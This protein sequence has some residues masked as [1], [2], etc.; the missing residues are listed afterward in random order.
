MLKDRWE[1]QDAMV[2]GPREVAYRVAPADW[3]G[4][5][6]YLFCAREYRR[7]LRAERGLLT[8]DEKRTV[9]PAA[10]DYA[11]RY[12]LKIFMGHKSPR[13]DGHGDYHSCCTFD[14][15]RTILEDCRRRGLTRLTA[16]LVGWGLDGHD[17]RYPSRFPVDDRLGGEAGLKRLLAWCREVDILLTVH[18]GYGASYA[19]SPEHDP[20]EL[21]R[22]RSGECWTSVIWSG[23]AC[24]QLCPEVAL[25]KYVPR[26]MAAL[27]ELG[28]AG[29][30][31][32]DAVGSFMPC[33][34]PAHP[35]T[36]RAQVVNA[37]RGMFETAIRE[38]GSV[39][40]EMPFGPYFDVVDG[41]YHSYSAPYAWHLA[42][43]VGRFFFD[44]SVPLVPA[45][46]NG[47]L[48]CCESLG[49]GDNWLKLLAFGLSPQS[50][51]CTRRS[52][53]FGIRE[54]AQLA[55]GLEAG[56]ARFYGPG[57]AEERI[58]GREIVGRWD[59]APGVSETLYDNGVRLVVNRGDTAWE[60]MAAGTAVFK[61]EEPQGV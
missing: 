48:H 24:N 61:G 46:V 35:L 10:V 9:R 41:F 28:L 51:V 31:H 23:G 32:I 39:S 55:D 14:E 21:I 7:F 57:G 47:S 37:V 20:A 16:V 30:L 1:Q 6:G 58:G 26:D 44:E 56:Y 3:E 50:E 18:D 4:G 11:G 22:H 40:T 52:P 13:A 12:F 17:G 27:R 33:F 25:R 36:E 49:T 43:P 15:A 19:C 38:L 54:Y 5:E 60:G 29:H 45:V 2:A 59:H 53:E 8:W 42:S 34:D